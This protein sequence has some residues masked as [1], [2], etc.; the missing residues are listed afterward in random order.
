MRLYPD[1]YT[2]N[3]DWT[4]GDC[5]TDYEDVEVDV[6]DGVAVVSCKPCGNYA[7]E[8]EVRDGNSE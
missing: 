2:T 7:V 4:C 3:I 1:E 5:D 8:L 6:Y